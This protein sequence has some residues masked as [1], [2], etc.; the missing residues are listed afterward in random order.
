MTLP[1]SNIIALINH[2]DQITSIVTRSTKIA[3]ELHIP[4]EILFVFETPLFSVPKLFE[5]PHSPHTPTLDKEAIRQEIQATLERLDY[6]IEV[7]IFIYIDDTLDRIHY[8]NRQRPN[9]LL[10]MRYHEKLSHILLQELT[11]PILYFKEMPSS[12]QR[13][14]LLIDSLEYEQIPLD[15]LEHIARPLQTLLIYDDK[16]LIDE[17]MDHEIQRNSAYEHKIVTHLEQLQHSLPQAVTTELFL[18]EAID[19]SALAKKLDNYEESL[20]VDIRKKQPNLLEHLSH[21]LMR[22]IPQ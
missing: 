7:A 22:I 1:F 19:D 5:L 18:D 13:L 21:D 12:Y 20:I 16:Y 6:P 11:I 9:T 3:H 8:L 4:L 15:P 14:V 17:S 10:I 2:P